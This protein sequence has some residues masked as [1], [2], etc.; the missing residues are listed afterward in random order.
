[1][2]HSHQP[3]RG[4][5]LDT[6]HRWLRK[7]CG[8]LNVPLAPKMVLQTI[9]LGDYQLAWDTTSETATLSGSCW[10][11]GRLRKLTDHHLVPTTSLPTFGLPHRMVAHHTPSGDLVCGSPEA[12]SFL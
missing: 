8:T 10:A 3:Q 9:N 7:L 2:S 4:L 5:L 12:T 6:A 11:E 1:M